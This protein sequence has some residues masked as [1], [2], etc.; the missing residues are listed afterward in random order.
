MPP[1]MRLVRT[2]SL[3]LPV[4]ACTGSIDNGRTNGPK[5]PAGGAGNGPP[6][7]T[8]APSAVVPAGLRRLTRTQYLNTV[9]ALLGDAIKLPDELD[10][11]D[12]EA[13][14]SSVGGYRITT[15]PGGVLKYED[16]AYDL[17][18]QVFAD[19]PLRQATVG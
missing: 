5:P 9:R 11:D 13:T 16:A 8:P 17:A 4:L 7:G 2:F 15:S 19:P 3:A 14:F 6:S 10:P 12:P 1:L 18:G